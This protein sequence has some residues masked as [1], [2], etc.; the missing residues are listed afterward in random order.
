MGV[1]KYILR[2]ILYA[3]P[4]VFGVTVV[5]FVVM[6]ILPGDPL[7][8]TFGIETVVRYTPEER[9]R[10][11]A[12]LGLDRSLL[13][14]YTGWIR[15]IG[16]G[17]LGTSLFRGDSVAVLIR[18]RGVLS[19]EIGVLAILVSWLVGLPVGIVSALRPNTV[20]DAGARVVS[21]MFLAIPGFWLGLLILLALLFWFGYKAP[22]VDVNIWVDPWKNFQVIVGPGVVLGL[23]LGAYVARMTR[24]S[25][26][27]VLREEYT[28][29][30]RA[31]GLKNQVVLVR[32]AL[33]N[34]LLPVITLSALQLGFV[35]GGSVAIERAFGVPGL[36]ASM[37]TAAVD[38]DVA[39]VQNLILLYSL[40]FV[41]VNLA[42]DL[43]YSWLDPRIRYE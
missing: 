9:A 43:S 28:R 23:G 14:Q 12:E 42:T 6:R 22:I 38:R 2:R 4:T 3:I 30:A 32:H 29:T 31:K 18:D 34:A 25:L 7:A 40:I 15:D 11:M 17:E 35:L 24:S 1:H 19:A 16:S 21:V 5:I 20:I 8:A 39:L 26:F 33:P 13:A 27:E 41:I 36:G 10:M 37:V